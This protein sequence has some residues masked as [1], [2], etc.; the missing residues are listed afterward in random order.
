MSI[1][2]QATIAPPSDGVFVA[3]ANPC[4][5]AGWA[6]TTRRAGRLGRL[7][8]RA[9]PIT[10]RRRILAAL[11]LAC[12]G[13][14]LAGQSA[15]VPLA[16]AA[17]NADAAHA[18]QHGGYAN[19]AGVGANG[20]TITFKNEGDCVGYAAHSGVFTSPMPSC[21]VTP[22]T[23]CLTFNNVTLPSGMGSGNS[24]T[25]TGA[26]AFDDTCTASSCLQAVFPNTLATGGGDYVEKDSSGA[27]IS[28]GSYRV[29][30]TAGSAEGLYDADFLDAADNPS[31][32]AAAS[33]WTVVVSAT[34]VDANTGATQTVLMGAQRVPDGPFGA[35]IAASDAFVGPV[36]I[37]TM[38][39]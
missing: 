18:C 26:T 36:P 21:S 4:Q 34:L 35:V 33:Q 17:G 28:S 39:C 10:H 9:L 24:I 30:A 8:A 20:Q 25:L 3:V 16:H 38:T 6:P 7:A 11:C 12:V 27:V 22:T 29:A 1:V 32:C 5:H 19:L 23:G 2:E 31:A 13:V 37:N 14:G 15:R